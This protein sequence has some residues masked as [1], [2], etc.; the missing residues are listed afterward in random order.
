MAA[1]QWSRYSTP[2][3]RHGL[4]RQRQSHLGSI[5]IQELRGRASERRERGQARPVKQGD[6][7]SEP[8]FL[9][10]CFDTATALLA[11]TQPSI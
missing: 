4:S 5:K 10:L 6:L 11:H 8:S 9:I 3:L 2:R 1:R 7:S